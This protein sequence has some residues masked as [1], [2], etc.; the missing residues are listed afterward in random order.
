MEDLGIE[1]F[2]WA[3][4]DAIEECLRIDVIGL[5][6]GIDSRKVEEGCVDVERTEAGGMKFVGMDVTGAIDWG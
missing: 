4:E 1:K 2:G 5:D 3:E 6:I